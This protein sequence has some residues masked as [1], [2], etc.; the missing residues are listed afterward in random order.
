VKLAGV[1]A[2]LTDP[3]AVNRVSVELRGQEISL[4]INEKRVGQYTAD[5]LV[6]GK[7]M[8]GVGPQTSLV[9]VRLRATPIR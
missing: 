8:V 6:G 5:A 2:I 7:L 3:N 9:L 1:G 4:V